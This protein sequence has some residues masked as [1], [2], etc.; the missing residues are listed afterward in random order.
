MLGKLALSSRLIVVQIAEAAF[1]GSLIIHV[2]VGGSF[3]L[4]QLTGY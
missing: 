3:H 4:E 1:L 2:F